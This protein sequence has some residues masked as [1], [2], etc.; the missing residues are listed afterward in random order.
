MSDGVSHLR[1]GRERPATKEQF[2]SEMFE[3]LAHELQ[4]LVW[5][6]TAENTG[7]QMLYLGLGQ[8]QHVCWASIDLPLEYDQLW[9]GGK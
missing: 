3:R 7:R 6:H 1:D 9:E 2:W 4:D 5:Q 8:L